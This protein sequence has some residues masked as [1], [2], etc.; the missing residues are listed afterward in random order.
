MISVPMTASFDVGLA[1]EVGMP[2]AILY[3]KLLWLSQ[4]DM[5]RRYNTDGWF[6]YT[7]KEFEDATDFTKNTYTAATD[8]LVK[9]GYIEKRK[10]YIDGTSVSVNHFRFLKYYEPNAHEMGKGGSTA[11]GNPYNIVNNKGYKLDFPEPEIPLSTPQPTAGRSA[12]ADAP[13]D[14]DA[15][16]QIPKPYSRQEQEA[17]GS[18]ALSENGGS[19]FAPNAGGVVNFTTPF[20]GEVKDVKPKS[21]VRVSTSKAFGI[22]KELMGIINPMEKDIASVARNVKSLLAKGYTERDLRLVARLSRSNKYYHDKPSMVVLSAKGVADLLASQKKKDF[23][24]GPE[25][26]TKEARMYWG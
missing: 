18:N 10:R 3:N 14:A 11:D 26:M 19:R 16:F 24:D 23:D 21:K 17:D 7:A 22:A 9:A 8:R 5:V 20:D 15:S 4:T 2:A 12:V 1:R 25:W 13:A 6:Y